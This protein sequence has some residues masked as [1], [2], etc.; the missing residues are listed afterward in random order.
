[1]IICGGGKSKYIDTLYWIR[2]WNQKPRSHKGWN[3][4]VLIHQWWKDE[5]NAAIKRQ[6]MDELKSSFQR[7]SESNDFEPIWS[8]IMASSEIAKSVEQ[9][10]GLKDYAFFESQFAK[11]LKYIVRRLILRNTIPDVYPKALGELKTGGIEFEVDEV[12]EAV[13]IVSKLVPYRNWR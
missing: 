4:N 9:S 10:G 12:L 6:F 7:V 8:M 1:L 3:R 5:Q 2:N 13:N 11:Y